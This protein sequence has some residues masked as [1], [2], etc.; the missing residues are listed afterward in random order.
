[1]TP[2][3]PLRSAQRCCVRPIASTRWVHLHQRNWGVHGARKLY[4]AAHH[5][6]F[7]IDRDQVARLM[8]IRGLTGAVH[9]R[10]RTITTR[11]DASAARHPDLVRRAWHSPSTTDQLWVAAFPYV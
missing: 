4:H 10:H 7:Q 8:R 3:R 5:A 2:A 6:G 1:M 9:G 11:G